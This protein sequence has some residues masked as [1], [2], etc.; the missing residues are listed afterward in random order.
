MSR[1][2]VFGGNYKNSILRFLG[3]IWIFFRLDKRRHG[4]DIG[5]FSFPLLL[6]NLLFF[7]YL[8]FKNA[9]FFSLMDYACENTSIR[10]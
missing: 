7:I 6:I 9:F 2:R 3:E 8:I 10:G 1:V 5:L 4:Q